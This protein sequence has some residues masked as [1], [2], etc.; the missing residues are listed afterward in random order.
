MKLGTRPLMILVATLA[1]TGCGD[2]GGSSNDGGSTGGSSSGT[3][4][5]DTMPSTT[6]GSGSTSVDDTTSSTGG[7]SDESG[8]STSTSSSTGSADETGGSTST[9]SVDTVTLSGVVTDFGSPN[10]LPNIEV[11]MFGQD[12]P[13][14]TTDA[15]GAYTL[16]GVPVAEGAIEFTGPS[17]F[18]S[19]F[20]GEGPMEDQTLDYNLLSTLAANVLAAV[21]GESIGASWPPA[22]VDAYRDRHGSLVRTARMI[23]GSHAEAEEVV[24]DAF[25]AT[26]THWD[27]VDHPGAYLRRCVVN[28]ANTVLRRRSVAERHRPDPPPPSAPVQL[29]ELRDLLLTLPLRQRAALVMRFVDDLDDDAIAEALDC[30]PGTV[31]SLVSRGLQRIREELT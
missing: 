19:L 23:L 26:L 7:S 1:A 10:P 12:I 9:G 3:T 25:V 16:D 30:A 24:H 28:G 22:L 17:R 21:L 8:A 11:C 5:D 14:A 6:S 13:C 27:T 18:P 20:W 2:D 31:R 29:V 15:E 4:G